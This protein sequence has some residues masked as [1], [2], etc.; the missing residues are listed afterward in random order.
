MGVGQVR[1]NEIA[2]DIP[3]ALLAHPGVVG[4][5]LVGSRATGE[6]GPLS[7]WDFRLDTSDFSAAARD[8]PRISQEL[9]ALA[10][11]WDR[12]SDHACFM[13]ML[14]GAV[15]VDLLFLDQPHDVLPPW[16]GSKETLEGIDWHSWDWIVWLASKQAKGKAGLVETELGKMSEHILRPMGVEMIPKSIEHAVKAYRGALDDWERKLG[17]TVDRNLSIAVLKRLG[18]HAF[19]V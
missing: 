10:W 4:V 12:L 7:D 15:K 11:Q 3:R 14:E 1:A 13:L 19:E 16:V 9:G 18:R 6:A 5:V 17:R 2:D 8:L